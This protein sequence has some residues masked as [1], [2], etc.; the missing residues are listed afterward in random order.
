MVAPD[1]PVPQDRGL[2]ARRLQGRLRGRL[3]GRRRGDRVGPRRGHPV[4]DDQERPDRP[5]HAARPR[6]PRR[7]LAGRLD[8]PRGSSPGWAS[9]SP[10]RAARPRRSPRRLEARAQDIAHLRRPRD[11]RV[12][13]EGRADQRHARR[14]SGRCSRSSR[15]SGS[16]TASSR[17][18]TRSA[19]ARKARERLIELITERPIERLAI[20]HTISPDVEAFRDEVLARAPELDPADVTI[21][22]VGAS[23]GPHLGPGCV[24]A[25]ILYR[26]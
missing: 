10:P 15:S 8:G 4:G 19:P 11:A 18:S 17:R 13:E 25:A 7:R 14:P 20:L 5:R 1:A 12:P 21:G 22:L 16:R 3:R 9:S 2:V 23:V 26:A 6:D 24:G